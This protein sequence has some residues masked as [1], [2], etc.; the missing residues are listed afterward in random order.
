MVVFVVFL[1]RINIASAGTWE[2]KDTRTGIDDLRL[3]TLTC[4]SDNTFSSARSQDNRSSLV[5]G[6]R[7]DGYYVMIGLEKTIF[8]PGDYRIRIKVDNNE[9][10]RWWTQRPIKGMPDIRLLEDP[11]GFIELISN[12]NTIKIE[13][14]TYGSG[15]P[16]MIFD[17]STLDL[18]K[19]K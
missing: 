11:K 17:T 19:F 9:S 8:D 16:V 18:S 12:A 6:K 13:V 4:M 14:P 3:Q 2:Y 1:M 5:I 10:R 15:S 7:D